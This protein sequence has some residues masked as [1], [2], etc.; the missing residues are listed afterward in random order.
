MHSEKGLQIE[1]IFSKSQAEKLGLLPGDIIVSVNSHMIRDPIDFM[2]YGS[3]TSI[4]MK[5]RRNGKDFSFKFFKKEGDEFGAV[6]KPLKPKTCRNNCIFCFVNQLPKGL[7]KTLYIKDD[8]YRLSFL[9]GNYITLTNLK[10]GDKERIIKQRLSPLYVSVHSTNRTLRN[11][12]LGN[13]KAPDIMKEL[14]FF[15][16]NK[17]RFHTQIVLCPDYNDGNELYKTIS[18]LHGFY[19]YVSSI[20]VVPVG[21]TS[22]RGHKIRPVEKKDA[23]DALKTISLFQRRFKKKYGEP[24]V[25]GADEL[26]IKAGLP[27]LPFKEYGDFPQIENGVGMVQYF[28]NSA[29]K[30]R[31]SKLHFHKRKFLSFTGIS[32]YPFLKKFATNLETKGVKVD[33]VPVENRFF[34]KTVTVTGLLTGKDIIRS[35]L[36]R[37]EGYEAVL[38]PDVVLKEGDDLFLDDIKLKD[39]EYVLKVPVKKIFSTPE[40][41]IEGIIGE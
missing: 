38:I 33:I 13:S 6:F 39:M 16:D 1:H 30:I 27:F 3:D 12:L 36:D 11:K 25:F 34:G 28:M 4:E 26:Y 10:E 41:L 21:L 20:A 40:G 5:V 32:F 9:Y 22:Y 18:D 7:R 37:V 23:N 31:F 29:K 14:K 17:I 19:P 8:D 15:T 35:L 2:F 24:I